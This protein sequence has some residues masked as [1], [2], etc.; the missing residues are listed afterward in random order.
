MFNY[1]LPYLLQTGK[2][3]SKTAPNKIQFVGK[4]IVVILAWQFYSLYYI[5]KI[6]VSFECE[7]R[8]EN[9]DGKEKSMAQWNTQYNN[10]NMV[11]PSGFPLQCFIRKL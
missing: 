9:E 1:S 4:I 8:R 7:G 6:A 2:L 3:I 11:E 10:N 5:H